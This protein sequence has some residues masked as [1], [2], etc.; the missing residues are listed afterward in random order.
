MNSNYATLSHW[1]ACFLILQIKTK[2]A[3]NYPCVSVSQW[4]LPLKTYPTEDTLRDRDIH[5]D[6]LIWTYIYRDTQL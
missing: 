1:T 6:K 5:G 2:T 3:V 4:W